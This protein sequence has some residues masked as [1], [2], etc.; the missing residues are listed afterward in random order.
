M[1]VQVVNLK[2]SRKKMPKKGGKD[3]KKARPP[4]AREQRHPSPFVRVFGAF[5]VFRVSRC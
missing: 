3:E 1:K 5:R 4:P 2:K